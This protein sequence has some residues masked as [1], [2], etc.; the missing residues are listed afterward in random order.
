[1][2]ILIQKSLSNSSA[3]K[4]GVLI[5]SYVSQDPVISAKCKR[6]LLTRLWFYIYTTET[7]PLP[8]SAGQEHSK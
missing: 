3:N 8:Q 6:T 4:L 1:M 5:T 2:E 7:S